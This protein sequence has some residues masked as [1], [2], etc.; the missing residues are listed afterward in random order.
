MLTS[1]KES[2]IYW[3]VHFVFILKQVC[4]FYLPHSIQ[5]IKITICLVRIVFTLSFILNSSTP[6]PGS[7][8]SW[9]YSYL[10]N[11]CLSPLMLLVRIPF[12]ARCATLCDKVCQWLATGRCFSPGTPLSSANKTDHHKQ[13]D[14][15]LKVALNIRTQTSFSCWVLV[16]VPRVAQC[17]PRWWLGGTLMM[18]E[19]V[20]L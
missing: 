7:Y 19:V 10:C 16:K 14:I 18:G 8:C 15:F 9:I 11:W 5:H 12:R 17:V 2:T 1:A 20:R 3:K 13:T 6:W 4:I